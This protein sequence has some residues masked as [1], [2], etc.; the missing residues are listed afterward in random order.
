VVQR[1]TKAQGQNIR[2]A[3]DVSKPRVKKRGKEPGDLR[4]LK[5]KKRGG[6]GRGKDSS[7]NEGE[8]QSIE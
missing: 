3:G 4:E 6:V 8:H 2:F 5:K 1:I 7:P